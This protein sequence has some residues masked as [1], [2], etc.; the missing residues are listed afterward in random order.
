MPRPRGPKFIQ[1][2]AFFVKIWQN[3]MLAPPSPGEL[4]PPPRGNPGSA[5]ELCFVSTMFVDFTNW[6][7]DYYIEGQLVSNSS[8]IPVVHV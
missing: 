7:Q 1:F 2:H 4:A 8:R 6:L 3:R 5:T